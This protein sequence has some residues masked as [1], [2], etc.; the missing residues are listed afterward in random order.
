MAAS[1]PVAIAEDHVAFR[2]ELVNALERDPTVEVVAEAADLARLVPRLIVRPRVV[3]ADA[4]APGRD[5]ARALSRFVTA[6]S[7]PVVVM[8]GPDDD[9]VRPLLAGAA[10]LVGKA[11]LLRSGADPLRQVS[12]GL[13]L[14]G[15][16]AARA[17]LRLT[18]QL[19]VRLDD[20]Q[21]EV[22]SQVAAGRELSELDAIVGGGPGDANR[23]VS[24]AIMEVRD[25]VR[26]DRRPVAAPCP[27]NPRSSRQ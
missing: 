18:R 15:P 14:L 7:P 23:S 9:A 10:G 27:D 17:L 16:E 22:L 8:L 6:T 20:R 3:L 13:P 26:R 4:S 25:A 1:L 5:V 19:G 2:R 11:Q 24:A 21:I 12:V